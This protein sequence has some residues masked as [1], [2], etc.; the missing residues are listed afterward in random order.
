MKK[1]SVFFILPDLETGGAERIVTTLANHLPRD[2]YM[3]TIVLLRRVGYFLQLLKDD[4]EVVDLKVQRIRSSTF[5]LLKLLRQRKPDIVFAGFGE[6]NAFLAPFIPFFRNTIFLAR[7]TNV[8]SKHVTRPEI[9]FFYRFYKNFHRIICQSDDMRDDLIQ[10]FQ[11]PAE[12]LIKINNPVDI[13]FITAKLRL[14]AKPES[15]TEDFKHIVAIGN[16]SARKGFDLLLHVFSF[17][18]ERK[19]KLHVLG[20]GRD[21][22][23][24][25][26]LGAELGLNNVIFHGQ[27]INPYAYLKY[28]D[29][30]VLSSRY[31]GFPNVL[32]EAGACGVF[33]VANDCPG[34]IAEIIMPGINGEIADIEKPELFAKILLASVESEKNPEKIQ[35][36]ITDRFGLPVILEKYLRVLDDVDCFYL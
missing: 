32:L 14:S 19:M 13:E 6:V 17:L 26:N 28:A 34:G 22:M 27:Q 5:P 18:K 7:E 20:T 4:V 11:L 29:L 8:V 23:Q 9:R 16:L 30:F 33:A 15:F 24:L 12:K 25:R 10:N 2:R 35:K 3:P 1:R 31:E 21:E 36:S